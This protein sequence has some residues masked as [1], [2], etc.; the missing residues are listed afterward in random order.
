MDSPDPGLELATVLDSNDPVLLGMA[1]GLLEQAGIPFYAV[2]SEYGVRFGP[3]TPFANPWEA[4]QVPAD[5]E[6]EA[7]ALLEDLVQ[8]NSITENTAK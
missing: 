3:V 5:R 7:R 4:I 6:A 1:K 2:G 8:G